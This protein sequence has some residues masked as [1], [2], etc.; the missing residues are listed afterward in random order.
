VISSAGAVASGKVVVVDQHYRQV[1]TL[2]GAGGWILQPGA[3]APALPG[4]Y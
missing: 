4:R 2:T 1:A 3:A